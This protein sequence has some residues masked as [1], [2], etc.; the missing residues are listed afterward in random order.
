M[1]IYEGLNGKKKKYVVA[2][3]LL[4]LSCDELINFAKKLYH[5]KADNV[6]V[7][8]G[9]VH[10]GLLYLENPHKKGQQTVLVAFHIGR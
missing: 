6:K 10:E 5:C 2:D 1:Q 3:R 8:A 9:W 4:N 7:T